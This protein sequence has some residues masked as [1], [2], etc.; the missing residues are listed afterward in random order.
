MSPDRRLPTPSAATAPWTARK[1]VARRLRQDTRWIAIPSPMVSMA[2]TS[3]T[4]TKAGSIVQNSGLSLRSNPG[5]PAAG[6]PNQSASP[7]MLVS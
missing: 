3:V 4:K 2:P 5:Q 1:S 7:T 6:T